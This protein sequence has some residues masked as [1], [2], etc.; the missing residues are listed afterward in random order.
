MTD[1]DF[2]LLTGLYKK[3]FH[4]DEYG[5]SIYDANNNL[6]IDVRGWGRI[7]YLENGEVK[8]DAFGRYVTRLLNEHYKP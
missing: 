4:Y 1:R 7:Q 2:K 3:P 8:Q 5:Q 6:A